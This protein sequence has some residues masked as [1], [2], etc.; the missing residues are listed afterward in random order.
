MY[1][2]SQL[3]I[4]AIESNTRKS[5]W[6]GTI[7]S[8]YGKE[9]SFSNEDI[10]KGSGYITKQC[11]GSNEIE[12][13]TVYAAEIG[14][15]LFSDIDRY[16]LDDATVSLFFHLVLPDNTEEVIP[17][18]V[19]E[20]S[21]AN[22]QIKTLE[23]KGYDYMLRFDKNLKLSSSSGK[24]FNFLSMACT[25]C[26]VELAQTKEEIESLPNGKETLGVYSDNDMSSFRDLIYYVAQV[27]GCICRINRE[28]KLELIKYDSSPTIEIP[29]RHRFDSSYSD[30]VTR[31]TAVSSTNLITEEAEYYSLELDDALTLN[32]GVNPLLQ[33]GLKSTREKLIKNILNA[34]SVVEYVPF[35]STTIGNPALDV[36]DIL[37]FSG[38]HA[39]SSKMSCITSITYKINGKHTLKCVGKNP[40]LATAK[41]KADKNIEGLMNQVETGKIV[42]YNFVN[43]SPFSIGNSSTNVMDIT[44]TSKEE[45]TAQF[46][47][48]ILLEIE[49]TE[50]TNLS[51]LVVVYKMNYEE[52]T[53][54]YPTQTY[55]NG[56]HILTL[57]FPIPQIVKNSSNV[58]SLYLK[59]NGGTVSI[60]ESQI[61][62]T[63]SGQGLVAGIGEWNGRIEFT[64]TIGFIP[65]QQ[66]HFGYDLF[67]ENVVTSL[68]RVS[69]QSIT[70]YINNV[71][72]ENAEFEY[73]ALNERVNVNEVIKTFTIDKDFPPQ[74][75][76]VLVSIHSDGAFC[77]VSDY[78][79]VSSNDEINDGVL[80]QLTI[81]TTQFERV[82]TIEVIT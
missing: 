56:K 30:F 1:P 33:F 19:F 70:Q 4:E 77:M 75:D 28:G 79:F 20:V 52:V 71:H 36:G 42:T 61:K 64:E 47:A 72:I 69:L 22:R 6:T 63:V 80:Q 48:T 27:L 2:V 82:E 65:I 23:L 50:S 74:Y 58:L 34:I 49:S 73:D 7:V 78:T 67:N 29:S 32:L 16:T 3:F 43:V 39:D 45:T 51:E 21:E 66:T 9:Y 37:T 41:S 11:C 46:H 31:Y 35:D 60:G 40:K 38:G 26:K 62:A 53:S 15:T 5:Y 54:F 57:F 10:V 12:L 24:A 81:N 13:G 76:P 44:F 14:I 18:G 25:E 59:V 8:K 68:P 17:M 55:I